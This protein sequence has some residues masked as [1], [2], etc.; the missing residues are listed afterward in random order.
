[1]V[2]H[3]GDIPANVKRPTLARTDVSIYS[4]FFGAAAGKVGLMKLYWIALVAAVLA[5]ACMGGELVKLEGA[6]LADYGGNDGDSFMVLHNGKKQVVR[7]YYVDCPETHATTEPDARRVREQARHFGVADKGTVFKYGKEAAKFSEKQLAKPFTIHTAYADARGRSP[8]GRIFAFVTTAGGQDLAGL[9]VDN[10]YARAYGYRRAL[11][12]GTHYKEAAARM[13][14]KETV[15]ALKG[16]GIWKET[17]PDRLVE[18]RA[19]SRLEEAELCTLTNSA[20]ATGKLDINTAS[21]EELKTIKGVGAATA[22]RIIN[23][24]PIKDADDLERIPRLPRKT[25]ANIVA[26]A[27]L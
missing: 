25:K 5:T 12:D 14:D 18:L 17:N 21:L 10:G 4:V 9:L 26:A 8:G 7:L 16:K 13:E 22:Q 23:L 6:R 11:P 1:M 3:L 2:P 19:A 27:G 20:V 15:A 24:R